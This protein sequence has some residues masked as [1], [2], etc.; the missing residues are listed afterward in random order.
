VAQKLLQIENH[1]S[2]QQRQRDN[3]QKR[4]DS[5]GATTM[6]TGNKSLV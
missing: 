5:R 2:T 3:K 4:Q 1:A 6:T